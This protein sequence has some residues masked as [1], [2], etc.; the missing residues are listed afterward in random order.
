MPKGKLRNYIFQ[1]KILEKKYT[2]NL[3]KKLLPNFGRSNIWGIRQNYC[4]LTGTNRR[5]FKQFHISTHYFR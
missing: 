4:L 1:K 2:L 5:I 3:K